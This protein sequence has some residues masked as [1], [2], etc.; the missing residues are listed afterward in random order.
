MSRPRVFSCEQE[1]QIFSVAV[2]CSLVVVFSA[3]GF[4]EGTEEVKS[5]SA[6]TMAPVEKAIGES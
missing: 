4:S 1:L 6:Y 5:F 3:W 2:V